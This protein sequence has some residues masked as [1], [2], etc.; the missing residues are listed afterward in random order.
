LL[1]YSGSAKF[2]KTTDGL[3]YREELEQTEPPTTTPLKG[4]REYFYGAENE[5]LVIMHATAGVTGANF[6]TLQF[7]STNTGVVTSHSCHLCSADRYEGSFRFLLPETFEITYRV[8]GPKKDYTMV[9]RYSR[10]P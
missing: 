5:N 6:M 10:L 4:F 1:K 3:Y 2:S 8:T 7:G 9:S